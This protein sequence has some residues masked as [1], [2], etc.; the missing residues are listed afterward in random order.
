MR[1]VRTGMARRAGRWRVGVMAA[2]LVLAAGPAAAETVA[3]LVGINAYPGGNALRGCVNDARNMSQ[4]L[5][6][7]FG[8]PA[9][10]LQLVL[11][12]QAT[13]DGILGAYSSAARRLGAG[14]TLI[15]FY[16]GHGTVFPDDRSADRDET[17]VLAAKPG[18]YPAGRYDN[19]IVPVDSDSGGGRPWRNLILDDELHALFAEATARGVFVVMISDSCH[20]GSLA[21]G[22]GHEHLHRFLPPAQALGQPLESL[23][24]A[25]PGAGRALSRDFQG[26]LLV[27][28]SSTDEQV[29]WEHRTATGQPV[30]LFTDALIRALERSGPG[31]TYE[32]IYR[33]VREDVLRQSQTGRPSAQE[34]QLDSRF[35]GQGVLGLPIF[36]PPSVPGLPGV[37]GLNSLPGLPAVPSVPGVPG[38]PSVPGLPGPPSLPALPSSP[39]GAGL[40]V[41]VRVLDAG[42]AALDDAF[43]CV[44]RP[45]ISPARGEIKASDTLILGKTDHRGLFDAGASRIASGRYRA[46]VVRQGFQVFDGEVE[47]REGVQRGMA[48]LSFRL[49][50]E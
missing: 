7:R 37:P 27:L 31:A 36:R 17:R 39:S 47:I 26:R 5:A 9:S 18:L 45:G 21:R 1:H 6:Q 48:V 2:G 44:F 49:V 10:N 22:A 41:V 12:Q 23:P 30:G 28:G 32:A 42:G 40:R 50:R 4:V 25:A 34:P 24:A 20:S 8:V 19:A 3:V 35:A 13:R 38:L 14:D 33:D 29:S 15:A 43:F 11:D 46:K 16:S